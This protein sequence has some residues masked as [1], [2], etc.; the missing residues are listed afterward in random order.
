MEFLE[1]VEAFFVATVRRGLVLR[2]ADADLAREWERR[3]VP[4]DVVR[5]GVE[6]GVKR[7][8]AGAEAHAPLPATL[9]YFRMSVEA[10]FEA[11]QRAR[12]Q[13]YV[14][15]AAA[16]PARDLNGPARELLEGRLA[17]GA[18][19]AVEA[20]IREALTALA[21]GATPAA[22][23]EETDDLLAEAAIDGAEAAVRERLRARVRAAVDAARRHGAGQAA[24]D[25]VRR[26]ETR[27]AA[28]EAGFESLVDALVSSRQ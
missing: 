2:Q 12:A 20:A 21:D 24:I 22:L 28:G 25:D 11:W 4:I 7:F 15:A 8:L 23:L 5:R 9:K 1:T 27:A 6:E 19:Q 14:P 16:A 18:T 17:G 13:G 10:E 26:A 3:G